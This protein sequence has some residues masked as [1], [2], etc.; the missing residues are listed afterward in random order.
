MAFDDEVSLDDVE[1]LRKLIIKLRNPP[2]VAMT[3]A[4][5]GALVLTQPFKL[6]KTK[7]KNASLK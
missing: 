7:E 2:V 5:T 3:F 4:F 6:L 1:T